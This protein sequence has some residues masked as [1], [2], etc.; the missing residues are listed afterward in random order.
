MSTV[1]VA[2]IQHG[3]RSP[4]HK[5]DLSE[6]ELTDVASLH[7]THVLLIERGQPSARMET[8]ARLA[9]ALAIQPSALMR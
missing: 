7:R 6:E 8:I 2:P 9:V 1:L 3:L 4:S 5:S